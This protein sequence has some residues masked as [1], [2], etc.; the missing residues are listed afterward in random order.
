MVV[1]GGGIAGLVAARDLGERGSTVAVLEARE[2]LGGR[3]WTKRLAGTE[4]SAEMGGTWFNRNLQ[5]AIAAEIDRYGLQVRDQPFQHAIWVG[6]GGRREG[7]DPGALFGELVA[8][9]R[10]ALESAV[11]AIRRAE[12]SGEGL[13]A[14]QDV[15]SSSWIDA[16]EVPEETRELLLAWMAAIGG[17]DPS[18]QSALI[19]TADLAFTG[20]GLE[21][22]D[23]LRESFGDGTASL[24]D[25]LAGDVRGDIH[26]ETVVSEVRQ[27]ETGVQVETVEGARFEAAAA[28]VALP[29]NCLDDI[30]FDP[31]LHA[32]KRAA[33]RQRHPGTT[34]KVLSIARGIE[35]RTVA[36]AWGGPLQAMVGMHEVDGG[37]LVAGF[38]ALSSLRDPTDRAEVEQALRTLAPSAQVTV[39][40]SHDWNGDPYSKGAWLSWRPGWAGGLVEELA[41]PQGRL[42]FAGSDIA[43][44]GAGYIEGA[45]DSGRGAARALGAL[46]ATR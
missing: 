25:A 43:I 5:P 30:G 16:L 10:P 34:T 22:L 29:L 7:S 1:L 11:K 19:L 37:T 15:A 24:V 39:A 20:Y 9:A 18:E 13:P 42:H 17:G 27:A 46:A 36:L 26:T 35:E 12:E 38:D 21:E 23:Q 45:I 44:E 41:Q 2:R 14:E 8:P 32:L 4:V 3:V 6:S 31:P 40:D 33:S 28:V